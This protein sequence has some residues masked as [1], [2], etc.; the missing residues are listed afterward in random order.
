MNIFRHKLSF[1]LYVGTFLSLFVNAAFFYGMLLFII[2]FF[3]YSFFVIG[4]SPNIE[5]KNINAL[6][7]FVFIPVL[8]IK[9]SAIGI[10]SY[11][12]LIVLKG[13]PL[14]FVG[15]FGLGLTIFVIASLLGRSTIGPKDESDFR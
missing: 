1:I 5:E 11:Y 3:S 7:K 8:L 13:S 2:T 9:F 12:V 14:W 4:M 10:V 15:G 6:K